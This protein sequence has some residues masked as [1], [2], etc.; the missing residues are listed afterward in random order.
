M[1]FNEKCVSCQCFPRPV[2]LPLNTDYTLLNNH[3][4]SAGQLRCTGWALLPTVTHRGVGGIC[5]LGRG[6]PGTSWGHRAVLARGCQSRDFSVS[7]GWMRFPFDILPGGPC[8]VSCLW[9]VTAELWLPGS[10]FS[11]SPSFLP[12]PS[13]FINK[14]W[15]ATSSFRMEHGQVKVG[16]MESF[17]NLQFSGSTARE[18]IDGERDWVNDNSLNSCCTIQLHYFS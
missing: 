18:C 6:S 17:S 5:F 11:S 14:A 8:L 10:L 1:C 16:A 13:L 15:P 3:L 4:Y 9:Q 7:G 12:F 2:R